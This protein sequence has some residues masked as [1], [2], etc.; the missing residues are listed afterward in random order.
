MS[1]SAEDAELKEL[2]SKIVS[3]L[4]PTTE[5]PRIVEIPYCWLHV[6]IDLMQGKPGSREISERIFPN[7]MPEIPRGEPLTFRM[8]V[9]FYGLYRYMMLAE[10]HEHAYPL[11]EAQADIFMHAVSSPCRAYYA[12]QWIKESDDSL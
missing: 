12:Y 8:G 6:F 1:D 7:L 2:C 4:S 3:M 11:T 9:E 5:T 10:Q